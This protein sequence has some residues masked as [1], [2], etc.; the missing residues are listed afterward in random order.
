[1]VDVKLPHGVQGLYCFLTLAFGRLK[2]DRLIIDFT[3]CVY[4]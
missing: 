3:S 4:L 1:M 2:L